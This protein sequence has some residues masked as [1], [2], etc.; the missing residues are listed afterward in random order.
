MDRGEKTGDLRGVIKQWEGLR[1]IYNIVLLVE[2]ALVY[3]WLVKHSGPL[4]NI[5]SVI[6]F[7]IAANAFY[8]FGPLLELYLSAYGHRIGKVRYVVFAI[9]L[10]FSMAIILGGAALARS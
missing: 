4:P 8:S 1:L 2:G 10:L 6:V 9:G 3:F 7:G 5:F